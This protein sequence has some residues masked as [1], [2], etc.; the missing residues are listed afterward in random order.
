VD[1]PFIVHKS[2]THIVCRNSAHENGNTTWA[3]ASDEDMKKSQ[4]SRHSSDDPFSF[5]ICALANGTCTEYS[6][7]AGWK[8]NCPWNAVE[9]NRPIGLIIGHPIRA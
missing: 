2:N 4:R 9:H 6:A 8:C 1:F 3:G 5:S 7:C